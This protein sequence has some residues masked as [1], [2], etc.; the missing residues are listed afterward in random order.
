MKM[1][2]ATQEIS[3]AL[4]PIA[5]VFPTDMKSDRQTRRRIARRGIARR[6]IA[7]R[8]VR[9]HLK[10]DYEMMS[11]LSNPYYLPKSI[12]MALMAKEKAMI[13]VLRN[14]TKRKIRNLLT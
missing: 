1:E 14:L 2:A 12:K 9:W 3:R 6:G 8:Y 10:T 13:K 4:A 5:E 11:L 7:R